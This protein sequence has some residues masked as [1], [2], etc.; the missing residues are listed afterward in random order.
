MNAA[1]LRLGRSLEGTSGGSTMMVV[2]PHFSAERCGRRVAKKGSLAAAR[3]LA[4][5]SS[6][7]Q[8]VYDQYV[9]L[10]QFVV[11]RCGVAPED[12]D[13]LVQETFLRL[14]QKAGTIREATKVKSWLTVTA[15]NLTLDRLRKASRQ[16]TDA[17]GEETD[18]IAD[19]HATQSKESAARELELAIVG[20]LIAKIAET[21]G[22]ETFRLFYVEGWSNRQIAEHN[23]E[24][25]STVTTRLSRMRTKFKEE[26]KQR[27]EESRERTL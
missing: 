24:A 11:D 13:E 5:D 12:R 22:G 16:K 7:F 18:G 26:L 8:A 21:P 9:G 19:P 20:D 15:R 4:G 27:I 10:V 3:W 6:A 2:A 25:L 14:H 23:G 17:A 1:F